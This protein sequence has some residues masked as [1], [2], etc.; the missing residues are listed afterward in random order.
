MPVPTS[1]CFYCSNGRGKCAGWQPQNKTKQ[2]T[3]KRSDGGR[4]QEVCVQICLLA[5]TALAGTALLGGK[6]GQSHSPWCQQ[7]CLPSCNPLPS[8][9][10]KQGLLPILYLFGIGLPFAKLLSFSVGRDFPRNKHLL[11][12]KTI[13]KGNKE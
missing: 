12:A 3:K 6:P 4:G 9:G 11:L 10:G 5:E 7:P 13:L 2:P 8:E 1:Q